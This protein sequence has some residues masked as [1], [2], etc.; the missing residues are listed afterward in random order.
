MIPTPQTVTQDSRRE[1]FDLA[2]RTLPREFE[3]SD[4][5][6]WLHRN[7]PW[8]DDTWIDGRL[9]ADTV[10]DRRRQH[11]PGARDVLYGRPDGRY[12]RYDPNAHG[13]WSDSGMPAEPPTPTARVTH[14]LVTPR[15]SAGR[16]RRAGR[17][18]AAG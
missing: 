14:L 8:I 18:R 3:P 16:D 7:A 17:R 13:W 9:V 2:L 10:N 15:P 6:A 4:V 5:F 12:E 11:M 1:A